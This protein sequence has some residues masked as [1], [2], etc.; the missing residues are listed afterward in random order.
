MIKVREVRAEYT[1]LVMFKLS[2]HRRRDET[3]RVV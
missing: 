3:R 2:L 1:E